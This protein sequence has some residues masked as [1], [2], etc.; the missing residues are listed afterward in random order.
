MIDSPAADHH[1]PRRRLLPFPGGY[2]HLRIIGEGPPLILLH[3][4]PRSSLSVMPLAHELATDFCCIAIDTPGYGDSDPLPADAG[5][6]DFAHTVSQAMDR[7]E[8]EQAFFY[9]THTGA[10][11]A[12]EIALR[13]PERVAHLVLDGAPAFSP[14][15]RD[16]LLEHYLPPIDA[17]RDG[18]HLAT[19]WA[20][21]TDQ[22]VFFPF[23]RRDA[24]ARA[25]GSGRD[26]ATAQRS[27]LGFLAAGEHYVTAYRAA[28]TYPT[29]EVDA[30]LS[31][32]T[33]TLACRRGDML[34]SHLNRLTHPG[35]LLHSVTDIAGLM[36]RVLSRGELP[37]FSL[38]AGV[39]DKSQGYVDILGGGSVRC[40]WPGSESAPVVFSLQDPLRRTDGAGAPRVDLSGLGASADGVWPW[41]GHAN[42]ED[43]LSIAGQALGLTFDSTARGTDSVSVLLALLGQNLPRALYCATSAEQAVRAYGRVLPGPEWGGGHLH[44]AWGLARDLVEDPLGTSPFAI[45]GSESAQLAAIGRLTLYLQYSLPF[46]LAGRFRGAPDAR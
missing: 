26:L 36:R 17:T 23:Y 30:A 45:A 25:G 10:A 32:D 5:I 1:M 24:A 7:L 35:V 15:E 34:A 21:V 46:L 20:R 31:A 27:I 28:I 6:G 18:R 44:A 9:G 12:M 3:E 19:L 11:I 43:A 22:Q 14:A 29:T 2:L 37:V 38:P 16:S 4:C 13:T 42:L 40:W 39:Q 41:Q 8:L 33:L